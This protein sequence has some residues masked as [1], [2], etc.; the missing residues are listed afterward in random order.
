[1]AAEAVSWH[2]IPLVAR[3]RPSGRSKSC[4][5]WPGFALCNTW[6][7]GGTALY[8]VGGNSQSIG[9]MS[10]TPLSVAVCG[11]LQLGASHWA[12]SESLQQVVDNFT[13]KLLAIE[14]FTFNFYRVYKHCTYKVDSFAKAL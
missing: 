10:L 3:Y 4:D 11:Q 5:V 13:W 8:M 14:D 1:M 7:S 2:Y 9:S 6:N 12:T